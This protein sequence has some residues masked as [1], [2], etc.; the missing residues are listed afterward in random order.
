MPRVGE[1]KPL[2]TKTS[3]VA[4]CVEQ[5][6]PLSP[7]RRGKLFLGSAVVGEITALK[8]DYQTMKTVLDSL[9]FIIQE[10]VGE[11]LK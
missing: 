9:G 4:W 7:Y 11:R 10:D 1:V 5:E 8:G 6:I 2:K 3:K